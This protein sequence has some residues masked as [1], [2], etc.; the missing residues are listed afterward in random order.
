MWPWLAGGLVMVLVAGLVV[1]GITQ[2]GGPGGGSGQPAGGRQLAIGAPAPQGTFTTVDGRTRSIASLRGKPTLLWFVA[3][4]CSPCQAGTTAVA[5]N[6]SKFKNLG[7][8]VVELK[9]HNNLGQ[10]GPGI[11]EFGRRYAGPAAHTDP[12]WT[13][14]TAPQQLTRTYDPQAYPDIYY[15]LD[16]QGRIRFVNTAPA[17]TMGQLLDRIETLTTNQGS[18]QGS[19][20]QAGN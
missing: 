12:S 9:L 7:A 11:A 10:P 14:G 4:W 19:G 20:T 15:L 2:R 1:L 16:P 6:L 8:Q 17:G 18:P 13:F 3:T 5:D